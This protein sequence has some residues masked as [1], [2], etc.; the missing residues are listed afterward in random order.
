MLASLLLRVDD[1]RYRP[2]DGNLMN[3]LGQLVVQLW[4]QPLGAHKMRIN[5]W[6]LLFGRSWPSRI[7]R[8]SG[9]SSCCVCRRVFHFDWTGRAFHENMCPASIATSVQS[10]LSEKAL[11]R[12]RPETSNWTLPICRTLL[13]SPTMKTADSILSLI[14][15]HQISTAQSSSSALWRLMVLTGKRNPPG[16]GPRLQIGIFHEI[17]IKNTQPS[18]HLCVIHSFEFSSWAPNSNGS[19]SY[20]RNSGLTDRFA[21]LWH[22][23]TT[24]TGFQLTVYWI[25]Q[26]LSLVWPESGPVQTNFLFVASCAAEYS[27]RSSPAHLWQSLRETGG[28]IVSAH[29]SRGVFKWL[30]LHTHLCVN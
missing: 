29:R 9:P 20:S 15:F 17:F 10:L 5:Q 8:G 11:H 24:A 21:R 14:L 4:R 30:P 18:G 28:S 27:L 1:K 16:L 6:P 19:S 2:L 7:A 25:F 13:S 3:K 12:C 26:E 23:S 22:Q